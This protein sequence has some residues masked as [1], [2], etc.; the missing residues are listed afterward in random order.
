MSFNTIS[1]WD[2]SSMTEGH[3][4]NSECILFWNCCC[5]KVHSLVLTIM[6]LKITTLILKNKIKNHNSIALYVVKLDS[7]ISQKNTC[8]SLVLRAKAK[9]MRFMGY[10]GK[11]PPR[12]KR[13]DD[14]LQALMIK[15][16]HVTFWI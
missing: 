1:N 8:D 6:W 4:E 10:S 15:N 5:K 13:G 16:F 3:D 9:Y 2:C 11:R 7:T 12:D 14:V